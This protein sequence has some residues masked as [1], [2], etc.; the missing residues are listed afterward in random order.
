M[1][2]RN[3][4]QPTVEAFS[5]A[6]VR[7]QTDRQI[8]DIPGATPPYPGVPERCKYIKFSKSI[9]HSTIMYSIQ[10]KVLRLY[11][12]LLN[13]LTEIWMCLI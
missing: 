10:E 12:Q 4:I 13:L 11:Q 3:N 7:S 9:F 5:E 2:G 6:P 1:Q 8:D